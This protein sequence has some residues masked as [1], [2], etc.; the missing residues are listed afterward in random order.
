MGFSYLAVMEF[1]AN[2]RV[3]YF[4]VLL[5]EVPSYPSAPFSFSLPRT[6]LRVKEA[7][8]Y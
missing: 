3:P 4:A 1:W 7:S 8:I 6:L 5:D 2:T